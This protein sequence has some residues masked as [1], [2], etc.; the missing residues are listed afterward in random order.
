MARKS[1]GTLYKSN[2]KLLFKISTWHLLAGLI[3]SGTY[4]ILHVNSWKKL[5]L[6][7]SL[8][9]ISHILT[10]SLI[11]NVCFTLKLLKTIIDN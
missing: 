5:F 10:T 8:I 3:H 6:R 1:L 4:Y 2:S 7:T 9:F 11:A